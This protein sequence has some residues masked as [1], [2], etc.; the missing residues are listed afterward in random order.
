MITPIEAYG[1]SILRTKCEELESVDPIVD[2]IDTVKSIKGAI[3]L[4]LPQIGVERQAFISLASGYSKLYINPIIRKRRGEQQSEEGCLS[5]PGVKE[6]ITRADII[7]V[8]FYD[9]SFTKQRQKLSDIESIVFQHEYDHLHGIMFTDYLTLEG[10]ERIKTQLEDIEQ[11]KVITVY[12]MSFKTPELTHRAREE[13]AKYLQR[14]KNYGGLSTV[15]GMLGA[16][17]Y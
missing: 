4:A 10:K 8:E 17:R 15:L 11:G 1:N 16:L 13:R 12:D 14:K 2:L 7:E 6:T 9:A 3:G 5:I